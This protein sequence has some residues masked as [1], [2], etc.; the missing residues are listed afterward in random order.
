VL[1]LAGLAIWPAEG[2][3]SVTVGPNI[4]ASKASGN[5]VEEC[6]AINP[7]NPNNL[8]FSETWALVTKYSTNGGV[9]WLNSNLSGLPPSI[10]DV[11]AAYDD[12]GNLFLVRFG[13]NESIVVGL[14]TNGGASFTMRYQTPTTGNDQPSITTGPSSTPGQGSVW[15]TYA[16]S[17]SRP[18]SQGALVTGLG[19]VGNFGPAEVAPGP[20]GSFGDIAIG[21]TGQVMVTY[22]NNGSGVGPDSIKVNLDPDGLGP[23]GFSP[24]VIATATQ[25]GGFAPITAQPSR[26]IDAEAGLAWDRSSGP[27]RGRVYLMYTDRPS[28]TSNDTDIYVRFSDDNGATWSA[29]V[30]ANDGPSGKSQFLP[31][32]ALDQTTGYIA[33][34]FYDCRNSAGNNTAEVWATVSTDGGLTFAPNVKVSGG[35]SSGTVSAVGSFNFGD[36]SGLAFHGGNF[37]PC[38]ADNSNSTGDNPNGALNAF[39]IYIARVT[40]S[41]GPASP[42]ISGISPTN[43]TVLMNQPATFAAIVTGGAPLT[44]QWLKNG[45]NI[46]APNT[47]VFTIASAQPADSGSYS[48]V[49]TNVSGSATSAVVTLNVIP[50]VP[51]PIALNNSNLNW[52]TDAATPWFGQTNISHDGFASARGGLIADGQQTALRTSVTGPGTLGF[53]WKVSSQ[54]SADVLSFRIGGTNQASISG[55]IDWEQRSVY[56]PSG[57]LTVDWIYSKDAN[58]SSG[59]DIAWVDQVS[60]STGF[61]LPF[62]LTQPASQGSVGGSPVTFSVSAGGTPALF[63]QWRHNGTNIPGATA[64]AFT[65]AAPQVS[66]SGDYSVRV[67]NAYGTILSSNALL[68]IVALVVAGD[69]SFGQLN[70]P[71]TATNV[72]AIGAGAWHSLALR[73]DG[74]VL[75]WG[76]N[77]NG[78]CDVPVN[79][80]KVVNIAAGGYHNLALTLDGTVIAWG[81]NDNGQTNVPL[82]ASNVIAIA[83][84]TWHSLALR[85]DGTVRGWGDNSWGEINVPAGLANVVAIAAGGS[86]SLA[87]RANGTVVGWGQNTDS[88]GSYVGQSDVPMNLANVV[89]ISAGEYHSLA[90]KSDGTIALWGDNSNGQSVVPADLPGVVLVAG[91]GSHNLALKA[92]G[93]V[94]AWG[95]NWNG[96]CSLPANLNSA[97]AIAAGG[98]HTLVLMGTA[99]PTPRL[100]HPVRSGNFFSALTQTIPGKKY[101]L[102]YKNSLAA[103]NW[104]E[105][106]PL[107]GIGTLQFL[108]DPTAMLPQRFYWLRQW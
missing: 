79:L 40:V 54:P 72:I 30:R 53:W 58:S 21:P 6:I 48:L 47:N 100:F 31:R 77:G 88:Q 25:V 29:P 66:D 74:K 59:M 10:G 55:E 34:S 65:I 16:D 61:T 1:A 26:T 75:A 49:V 39:D 5:N 86:H 99:S 17:S 83:A 63:Y 71:A 107:Y 97:V 98:L 89:A 93:T 32:I 60:Y 44:Y 20:G 80:S 19:A 64:T 103:T 27:H 52:T 4:N 15:I 108:V 33:V 11:A 35:I 104:T 14:S 78:Q 43:L 73:P 76:N 102:Q 105:L 85:A 45:Q 22:Q 46:A 9:T 2:A 13:A 41:T 87:L 51:L 70:V 57:A 12:F 56:L 62:I 68:G 94:A 92:N 38:W 8:F 81:A 67:T 24:V 90:V 18:T 95:N 42:V 3:V 23:A 50:T 37:Y 69:N 36:Y 106:P 101:T 82:T 7:L 91:G 96:Q 28:T 84:G